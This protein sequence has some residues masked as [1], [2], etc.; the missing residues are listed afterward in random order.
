MADLAL[1][2]V[3]RS[4]VIARGDHTFAADWLDV[5]LTRRGDLA[6]ST[7]NAVVIQ[8]DGKRRVVDDGEVYGLHI[9]D[10]ATLVWEVQSGLRAEDLR[11]L[12]RPGRCPVRRRYRPLMATATL[13]VTRGFYHDLE[14]ELQRVCVRRTGRDLVFARSDTSTPGF[15]LMED[16]VATS[17]QRV[18]ITNDFSNRYTC[19]TRTLRVVNAVTRRVERTGDAGCDRDGDGKVVPL[20][21]RSDTF[22]FTGAGAVAF[23]TRGVNG[24]VLG[25][26]PASEQLV[27][28]DAGPPGSIS[29]LLPTARGLSW[30]SSGERRTAQLP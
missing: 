30:L 20:P 16:V 13:V 25:A 24:D 5:A 6:W 3:A 2:R 10:D 22:A 15:D 12:G 28:L 4:F 14:Q 11:P 21:T 26:L 18:V 9:E 17:G 27:A 19:P 7:G 1:L 23:V 8:Q 29:D